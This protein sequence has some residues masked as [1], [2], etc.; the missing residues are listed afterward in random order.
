M[1]GR[2]RGA[3]MRSVA[4]LC[5]AA[6]CGLAV[7]AGIRAGSSASDPMLR[8]AGWWGERRPGP[9]ARIV[10]A[11]APAGEPARAGRRRGSRFGPMAGS[12]PEAGSPGSRWEAMTGWARVGGEAAVAAGEGGS[13]DSQADPEPPGGSSGVIRLDGLRAAPGAV[14]AA[15]RGFDPAGPRALVLWR[16]VDGRAVRLADGFSDSSGAL[17]FPQVAAPGDSM[18]LVVSPA[19][20][21]PP[22][23]DTSDPA[24]VAGRAPLPP[25]VEQ[26]RPDAGGVVLRIAARESSG[27]VLVASGD[28]AL[29]GRFAL[30]APSAPAAR[31]L[32]IAVDGRAG[33]AGLWVAQE[34]PDGRRSPFEPVA[35]GRGAATWGGAP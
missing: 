35:L 15:P 11:G 26:V 34:L 25:V 12:A 29:L 23:H 16:V 27:A 7:V 1:R 8:R 33:G 10:V 17:H 31:T 2:Q 22:S 13:A 14:S 6:A 19:G 24:R 32:E 9:D 30:P 28:G 20:A 5:L 4:R 21:P 3:L 18:A